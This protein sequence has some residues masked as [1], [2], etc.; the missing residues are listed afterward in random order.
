MNAPR[1]PILKAEN[2]D[3]TWYHGSPMATMDP[4][5]PKKLATKVVGF[6]GSTQ[7]RILEP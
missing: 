6:D 2:F 7:V 3:P 5:L 4:I 1:T